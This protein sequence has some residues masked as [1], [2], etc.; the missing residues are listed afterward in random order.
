MNY[1]VI[2]LIVCVIMLLC[3]F[4]SALSLFV[5]EKRSL[6]FSLLGILCL[7]F[8]FLIFVDTARPSFVTKSPLKNATITTNGYIGHR[9]CHI[10]VIDTV[11]YVI[12]TSGDTLILNKYN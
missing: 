4:F 7:C 3:A 2:I 11:S 10:V 1:D 6:A 12:G 8:L 9:K 5:W